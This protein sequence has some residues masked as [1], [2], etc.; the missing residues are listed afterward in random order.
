MGLCYKIVEI[1]GCNKLE[2]KVGQRPKL[3]C[4]LT[5]QVSKTILTHVVC[6]SCVTICESYCSVNNLVSYSWYYDVIEI[7][8]YHRMVYLYLQVN[9][10]RKWCLLMC[11]RLTL[12][13]FVDVSWVDTIFICW[14][15]MGWHHCFLLM[16][17]G[18][19]LLLFINVLQFDTF[20]ICWFVTHWHYCYSLMCHGLTVL[21]FV[22]GWRAGT[23]VIRWRVT[24]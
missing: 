23:I 22:D 20:V 17:H 12:F 15:V 4:L 24:H 21:L 10:M 6:D 14:R 3:T 8:T 18:L 7:H 2:S 16:C 13:L 1:L 19:T 9:K 5:N 11:H